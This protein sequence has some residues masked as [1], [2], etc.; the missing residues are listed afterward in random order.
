MAEP[1]TRRRGVTV[2]RAEALQVCRE[3]LDGVHDRLPEAAFYFT[4]GTDE[5]RA[6]VEVEGPKP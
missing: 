3:T 1:Y 4:G 5:I 6:K 2:S